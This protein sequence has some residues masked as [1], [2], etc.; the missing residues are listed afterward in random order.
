MNTHDINKVKD[1]L[2]NL[3]DKICTALEGEE[4]NARFVEDI[5]DRAEG[6]GGR[7]RVLSG[8]VFEQGGV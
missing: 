8:D 5:W 3:Q 2:L 4:P 1:Y 6:G 7:S